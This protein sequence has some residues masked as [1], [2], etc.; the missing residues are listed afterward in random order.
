MGCGMEFLRHCSAS[1][2]KEVM[3]WAVVNT[4][5]FCLICPLTR[6]KIFA[7][8]KSEKQNV[9]IFCGV[10]SFTESGTLE[11]KTASQLVAC[12]I[13]FPWLSFLPFVQFF[14]HQD[15]AIAMPAEFDG[16]PGY[17]HGN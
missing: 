5:N 4:C 1:S 10:H 8:H 12:K 6:W 11:T 2:N 15:P 16:C 17:T 7:V 14:H 13:C 9:H 3:L